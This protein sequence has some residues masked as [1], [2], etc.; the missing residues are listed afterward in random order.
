LREAPRHR[1]RSFCCGAGGGLVYLGEESGTRVSHARAAELLETGAEVVAAACPFCN[2]ML[3][4][5]LATLAPAHTPRL[6]D[7]AQ[8]VA[9]RLPKGETAAG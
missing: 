4:D 9:E 7:I 8:L 3:R 2:T 6:L 5:A 1:E